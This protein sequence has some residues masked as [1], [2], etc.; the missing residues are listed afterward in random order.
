MGNSVLIR[1]LDHLLDPI[2]SCHSPSTCAVGD[3]IERVRLADVR[4]VTVLCLMWFFAVSGVVLA[5]VE[6]TQDPDANALVSCMPNSSFS[7]LPPS[8]VL[9]HTSLLVPLFCLISSA[10][11]ALFP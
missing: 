4:H 10:S 6:G 7:A 8:M 9:G 3:A 1:V 2:S 11:S 5:L